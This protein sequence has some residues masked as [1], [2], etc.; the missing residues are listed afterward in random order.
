MTTSIDAAIVRAAIDT[1]DRT[2]GVPVLVQAAKTVREAA[3]VTLP[4]AARAVREVLDQPAG[5]T[6][7]V[8]ERAVAEM[9]RRLEGISENAAY[10]DAGFG[11][12]KSGDVK[13]FHRRQE[14][15]RK[16]LVRLAMAR[17]V[18]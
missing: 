9:A 5:L 12:L 17:T 13:W 10:A 6:R 16:A 4:E 18:D 15:L 2:N 3:G 14:L 8:K 11:P 1:A 7:A